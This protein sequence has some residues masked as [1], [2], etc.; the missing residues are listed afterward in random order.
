VLK[1]ERV[2]A[3]VGFSA[4]K[5][6]E[7]RWQ[8]LDWRTVIGFEEDRKLSADSGV[9]GLVGGLVGGVKVGVVIAASGS[10]PFGGVRATLNPDQLVLR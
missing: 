5:A 4:G 2:D 6:G 3:V 10:L 7:N 8:Y 1:H 9:G